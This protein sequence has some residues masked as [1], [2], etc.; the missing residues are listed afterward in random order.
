MKSEIPILPLI[1]AWLALFVTPV[2]A[3]T[4]HFILLGDRTG[5]AQPGVYEQVWKE[6]TSEDPAF[7]VTVGDTIQGLD[8]GSAE[9]E[10]Q[11]VQQIL[12][13]YHRFP[14]YPAAGN[15]DIWSKTSEGLFRK[16][17]VHEPHYSFD[18]KQAHFTILDNSRAEQF[19]A[20]ELAFL[21]KDLQAH[22]TQPVKFI[23]SHRPSWILQVVLGNPAFPLHQLAAR[24]HVKYVIAGHIHQMLRFELDGVT[25]LSMASSG[26]HL[27]ENKT[28]ER[29]WFFQHTL[30]R[31][32][33]NQVDLEI[34][35]LERPYGNRRVTKPGDWGAAGL[36]RR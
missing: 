18:Y 19:S 14:F 24:Y 27:R 35:E 2:A 7:V 31:V 17:A 29:G 32:R 28:Y 10:W 1:T 33:G 26:G 20:E 3:Q 16:Y 13:P 22:A 25:Y 4:F 15:H 30:A 21:E 6:A 34:K 36:L 8:D 12:K 9:G 5:E 11:A 23:V